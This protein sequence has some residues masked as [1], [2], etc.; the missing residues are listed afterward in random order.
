M[1]EDVIYTKAGENLRFST[2]IAVILGHGS[3]SA[4]IAMER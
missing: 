4:M 2:E 1:S 3:R